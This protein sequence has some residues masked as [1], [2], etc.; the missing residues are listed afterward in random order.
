MHSE[1]DELVGRLTKVQV[2]YSRWG[3]KAK[4]IA[5]NA[6]QRASLESDIGKRE[7]LFRQSLSHQKNAEKDLAVSET[8]RDAK[9]TLRK[10]HSKL[11]ADK[12]KARNF[13]QIT[14]AFAEVLK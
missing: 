10:L 3:N 6:E 5:N 12:A 2:M 11:L 14:D 9:K 1:I 13:E 8:M 7:R 4:K